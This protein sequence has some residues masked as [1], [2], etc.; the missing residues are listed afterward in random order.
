[1][2]RTRTTA[3][4][5]TDFLKSRWDFLDVQ[6]VDSQQSDGLPIFDVVIR[7]DGMYADVEMFD[8]EA[9]RRFWRDLLVDAL[10]RDGV[11]ISDRLH[12]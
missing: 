11:Q 9:I 8:K 1:M 4:A 5:L 6:V 7:I 3:S 10:E 12:S 2:T